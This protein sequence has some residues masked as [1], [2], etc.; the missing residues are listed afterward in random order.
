MT[1]ANKVSVDNP[2]KF[3]KP[4]KRKQ[5][6][7]K[8]DVVTTLKDY[9]SE[10]TING[11]Q[12]LCNSG[13]SACGRLFWM[14]VVIIA[15]ICTLVVVIQICHQWVDDPVLTTLETI[16]LP[17]EQIDFPAV[18]LC[19]QGSTED[20]IDN[21]FYQQFEEW[22]FNHINKNV[23]INIEATNCE[24]S[25]PDN[26]SMT[27]DVLQ[28]CSHHYLNAAFP[29]VYPNNPTK[30]AAML[31]AENPDTAMEMKSIVGEEDPKCD[32]NDKILSNMNEKLQGV[33]PEPF[34][35]YNDSF[36]IFGGAPE[37]SYNEAVAYCKQIGGADV[38]HLGS[39][40]D[41][42]TLDK[43]IG[44]IKILIFIIFFP[45]ISLLKQLIF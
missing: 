35:N 23:T 12:Y 37:K 10:S 15:L 2:L 13:H 32:E 19:P 22:V 17:V 30:M 8:S 9:S 34:Y 21:F 20:L 24:C 6:L 4:R 44:K 38:Y 45:Y 33:C 39:F 28:C 3:S 29:G 26:G 16:S 1:V 27:A 7:E 36:C 25:L 43:I 14:I 18:T 11:I 41:R 31:N 40:E 42:I 5:G